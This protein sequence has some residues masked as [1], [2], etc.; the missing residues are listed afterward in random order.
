H[1]KTRNVARFVGCKNIFEGR[2]CDISDEKVTVET[3]NFR[4]KTDYKFGLSKKVILVIRPEKILPVSKNSKL[5]NT[6]HGK[7]VQML[8]HGTSVRLYFS[9]TKKDFDFILDVPTREAKRLNLEVSKNIGVCIKRESIHLI[10][11]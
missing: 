4:V 8:N 11:T 2:V 3:A 5:E 1:P 10:P 7:I 9:F 6:F